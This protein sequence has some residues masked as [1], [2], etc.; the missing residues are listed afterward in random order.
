MYGLRDECSRWSDDRTGS[1]PQSLILASARSPWNPGRPA[2]HRVWYLSGKWENLCGFRLRLGSWRSTQEY[3]YDVSVSTCIPVYLLIIRNCLF[4]FA[5][6]LGH[7]TDMFGIQRIPKDAIRDHPAVREEH[8]R[9]KLHGDHFVV[10]LHDNPANPTPHAVLILLVIAI[11]LN[12]IP[13]LK[14]MGDAWG[15]HVSELRHTRSL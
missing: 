14:I 9:A 5:G 10:D 12:R 11:D 6:L 8:I 15:L 3:R 4:A 7:R 1:S 2:E 13:N